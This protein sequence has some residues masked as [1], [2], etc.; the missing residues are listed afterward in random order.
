[1]EYR[2]YY[3]TLGVSRTATDKELSQAFRKLARKYHPDT[4]P[5][6]AEA[7]KRFKAINEAYQVLSD[8]DKRKKYDHLGADWERMGQQQAS[9]QHRQSAHNEDFSDFFE[10]FFSGGGGYEDMAG[11]IFGQRGAKRAAPEPT[12]IDLTVSLADAFNGAK[13]TITFDQSDACPECEGGGRI[14]SGRGRGRVAVACPRCH[15]RGSTIRRRTLTVSIPSGVAEGSQIRLAGEGDASGTSDL[16]FVVHLE[17]HPFYRVTGSDLH[18]DLPVMDYE[19]VLGGELKVPT[20]SGSWLTVRLPAESQSGK[21]MRLKG[22]G[23]P[24]LKGG[25]RGDL[26]IMIKILIP[27]ELTADERSHFEALAVTRNDQPRANLF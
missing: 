17:P 19:A 23:I 22:Q 5:N 16:Y 15:G 14:V 7:E 21:R 10:T 26:Y 11:G 12:R 4:H 27:L 24:H 20:L 2:D 8:A 3:E 18:C 1:M 13:K 6:D 9:R 25:E